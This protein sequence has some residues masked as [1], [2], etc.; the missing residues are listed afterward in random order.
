M[1]HNEFFRMA[2]MTICG[3]LKIEQA[4]RDCI[5]V[6]CTHIPVDRMFLQ[7]YEP[8]LGAMRTVAT[9]SGELSALRAKVTAMVDEAIQ[10]ADPDDDFWS[11]H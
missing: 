6:I 4:M 10:A 11:R 1:D 7:I 8:D 5:G 9:A 3:N 2:T